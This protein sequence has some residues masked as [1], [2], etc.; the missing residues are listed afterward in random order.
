MRIFKGIH[1]IYK[2]VRENWWN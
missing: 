2:G 1:Y